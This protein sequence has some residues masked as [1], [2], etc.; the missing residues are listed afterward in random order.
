[1]LPEVVADIAKSSL[2]V[3]AV[4]IRVVLEYCYKCNLEPN[5]ILPNCG[6]L[7]EMLHHEDDYVSWWY[8]EVIKNIINLLKP[9]SNVKSKLIDRN[10]NS[11]ADS[12]SSYAWSN[13]SLSLHHWV[14][15]PL[16]LVD[17]ALV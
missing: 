13:L 9:G 17:A 5:K 11:L 3:K 14:D 6:S 7:S 2:M 12:L 16:L 1:M 4:A 8:V 10:Y 15:P